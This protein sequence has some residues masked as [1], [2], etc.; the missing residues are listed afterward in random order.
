MLRYQA[1][2]QLWGPCF[3]IW[4]DFLEST[5][6]E[7]KDAHGTGRKLMWAYL[8]AHSFKRVKVAEGN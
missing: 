7:T 5:E 1:I 4:V 3:C 6:L 8:C 2:L